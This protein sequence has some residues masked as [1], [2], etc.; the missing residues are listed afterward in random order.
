MAEKNDLLM[1]GGLAVLGVAGYLI[2]SRMEGSSRTSNT[3]YVSG[4]G[5]LGSGDQ[6]VP[7]G[8]VDGGA[9]SAGF[10]AADLISAYQAGLLDRGVP[11]IEPPK[12][13]EKISPFDPSGTYQLV[14]KG[15][16]GY[17]NQTPAETPAPATQDNPGIN[18]S[19]SQGLSMENALLI[20]AFTIPPAVG[21]AI[22]YGPWAVK[23]GLGLIKGSAEITADVV[24]GSIEM[25]ER[26]A[27]KEIGRASCRE[28][29]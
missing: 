3:D 27:P 18:T 12:E 16:Y 26:K 5:G 6:T 22:K 4:A 21:G 29:V 14:P 23:Q 10:G 8:G 28:R 24:K 17:Q 11:G 20:G 2:L 13:E 15:P 1:L 25:A 7:P 19:Q 9:G